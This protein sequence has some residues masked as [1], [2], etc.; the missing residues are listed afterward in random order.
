MRLPPGSS[1]SSPQ[2]PPEPSASR[3]EESA[4]L[5]GSSEVEQPADAEVIE[6]PPGKDASAE[7]SAPEQ[8]P[9]SGR[10]QGGRSDA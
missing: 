6:E 7:A 10:N 9:Q 1:E 5:W 3:I 4:I 2:P 8:E